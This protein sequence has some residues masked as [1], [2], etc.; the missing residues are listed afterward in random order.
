M[1][2]PFTNR[3]IVI[4]LTVTLALIVI[5]VIGLVLFNSH[6]SSRGNNNS[7]QS[8][9]S[10][11]TSEQNSLSNT[12]TTTSQASSTNSNKAASTFELKFQGNELDDTTGKPVDTYKLSYDSGLGFKYAPNESLDSKSA[13][14]INGDIRIDLR[15]MDSGS[16]SYLAADTLKMDVSSVSVYGPVGNSD[17]GNLYRYFSDDFGVYMYGAKLDN[18][19][20]MLEKYVKVD[21]AYDF[22]TMQVTCAASTSQ[23]VKCDQFISKL[24]NVL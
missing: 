4:A 3:Q 12:S 7:D 6:P 1:K 20:K 24:R 10:S 13:T 15:L 23:V 16:Y 18:S 5:G 19:T 9:G 2:P 14:F 17:W 11:T 22:L 21:L 8:V